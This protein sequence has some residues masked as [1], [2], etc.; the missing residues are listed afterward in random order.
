M[1]K[2]KKK[3]IS[4]KMRRYNL[5][6]QRPQE[7]FRRRVIEWERMRKERE[8]EERRK[9]RR[10]KWK[11]WLGLADFTEYDGPFPIFI[12]AVFFLVIFLSGI[13]L[14]VLGLFKDP[15]KIQIMPILQGLLLTIWG[16]RAL[17]IF[18]PILKVVI[19]ALFKDRK[20]RGILKIKKYGN[21]FIANY[22]DYFDGA[23]CIIIGCLSGRK[24]IRKNFF[25]MQIRN[26]FLFQFE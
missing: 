2:R 20:S 17:I 3:R 24:E 8:P 13:S 23:A 12:C 14:C 16:A 9:E 10:R 11:K 4:E 21:C 18:Y 7:E 26:S 6:L 19:I 25:Y 15:Y 5:S 22:M 1:T